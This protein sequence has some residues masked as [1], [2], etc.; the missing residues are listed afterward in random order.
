MYDH[1]DHGLYQG[2]LDRSFDIQL[3]QHAQILVAIFWPYCTM[4]AQK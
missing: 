3:K 4:F 1:G 2:E